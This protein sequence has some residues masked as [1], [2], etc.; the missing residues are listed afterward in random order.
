MANKYIQKG[1]ECFFKKSFDTALLNFSLA[2]KEVDDSKEARIGAILSDL[3]MEKEDEAGALFEYYLLSK[4]S[5]VKDSEDIIEE[6][7]N[8]VEL[9]LED[10]EKLFIENQIETKLNEESGIAYED[11]L[12][13][14]KDKNNFTEAFENIMFSTK[15]IIHKKEDFLDFLEQLLENGYKEISLNYLETAIKMF[16]NDEKLIS[17]IKKVH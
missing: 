15:V 7:I 17:L 13:V 12:N 9:S 6:I 1:I 11:F 16:P 4:D 3:A 5:G 14:V 2:L 8:S 10:I